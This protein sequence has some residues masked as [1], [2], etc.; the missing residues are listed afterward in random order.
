[1][2]V[3]GGYILGIILVYK[4]INYFNVLY[5]H[6]KKILLVLLIIEVLIY[7]ARY[8]FNDIRGLKED[9]EIMKLMNKT[10]KYLTL[11]KNKTVSVVLSFSF[12]FIKVILAFYL[13]FKFGGSMTTPLLWCM[14]LIILTT[15]LYEVARTVKCDIAI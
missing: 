1:M 9:I 14:S 11:C 4:P 10:N 3:L 2:F 5:I 8:Q 7:Q 12:I 6:F 15:V 13:T